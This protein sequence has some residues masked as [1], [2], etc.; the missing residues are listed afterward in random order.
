MLLISFEVALPF[1]F[2]WIKIIQLANSCCHLCRNLW[3]RSTRL[4]RFWHLFVV[5]VV[6]RRARVCCGRRL[7]Y[8]STSDFDWIPLKFRRLDWKICFLFPMERIL[9]QIYSMKTRLRKLCT[10]QTTLQE[11]WIRRTFQSRLIIN[12]M[13]CWTVV[14][15]PLL[16]KGDNNI[17]ENERRSVLF[18][19]DTAARTTRL[20]KFPEEHEVI[21]KSI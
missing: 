3:Y 5:V 17:T 2:V 11:N 6:V 4:I 9:K 16:C 7:N 18:S 15:R 21:L 14:Q 19:F 10:L 20:M 13:G 12:Q 1:F 8:H